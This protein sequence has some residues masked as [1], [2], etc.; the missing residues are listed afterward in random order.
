MAKTKLQFFVKG[1]SIF[2][3]IAEQQMFENIILW[4]YILN[5]FISNPGKYKF[6]YFLMNYVLRPLIW[7]GLYAPQTFSN[8]YSVLLKP[9]KNSG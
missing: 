7:S 4:K 9:S 1:K 3:R 6:I 2:L 8:V 5:I